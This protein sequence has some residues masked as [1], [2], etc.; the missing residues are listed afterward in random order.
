MYTPTVREKVILKLITE[1]SDDEVLA[2][3]DYIEQLHVS[4]LVLSDNPEDDPMIGFISGPTDLAENAEQILTDE[5]TRRSGW[6]Q[7]KD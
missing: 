5:I 6:T 4:E 7:K 1:L 3:A 2:V